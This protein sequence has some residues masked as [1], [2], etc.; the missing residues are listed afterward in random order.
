MNWIV[1]H[2]AFVVIDLLF[3]WGL[4]LGYTDYSN[5]LLNIAS[6]KDVVE[7]SN[8]AGFFVV[9]AGI[10]PLHFLTITTD[11]WP[12]A[13]NR[14]SRIFNLFIVAWVICLFSS[15]IIG[16]YWLQFKAE[17][18]GY[19]Y[20]REASGFSALA[21]TLVYTKVQDNCSKVILQQQ[22][23]NLPTSLPPSPR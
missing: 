20:C 5:A 2:F 22:S 13:I 17:S 10:F 11:L 16:S 8:R 3:L 19:I 15:G 1:R 9:C 18:E 14:F 7:F 6:D 23:Y 21:R 4:S 12:D